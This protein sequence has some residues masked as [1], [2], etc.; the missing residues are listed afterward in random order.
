MYFEPW[1]YPV[2]ATSF[3]ERAMPIDAALGGQL[4]DAKK[5]DREGFDLVAHS[6]NVFCGSHA[7]FTPGNMV[8]A[9][10]R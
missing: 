5:A 6:L 8:V 7:S 10:P 4:T 1:P 2:G 9:V 3:Q